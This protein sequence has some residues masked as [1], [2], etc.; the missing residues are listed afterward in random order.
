MIVECFQEKENKLKELKLIIRFSKKKKANHRKIF[1][2]KKTKLMKTFL[3]L[4][5]RI[6]QIIPIFSLFIK[7]S[8]EQLNPLRIIQIIPI[9][10]LFIKQSVEQ[11]NHPEP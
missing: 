9:F 6:I 8:V 7:Q 5:L 11:L 3:H 2:K 10:S 1:G 4:S